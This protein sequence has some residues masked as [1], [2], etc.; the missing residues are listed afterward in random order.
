MFLRRCL[1]TGGIKPPE[2]AIHHSVSWQCR[3]IRLRRSPTAP[4]PQRRERPRRSARFETRYPLCYW[5]VLPPIKIS[6]GLAQEG[7]FRPTKT[8]Q[9]AKLPRDYQ[10]LNCVKFSRN[11]RVFSCN[12]SCV[13]SFKDNTFQPENTAVYAQHIWVSV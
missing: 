11:G 2:P 6:S 9:S 4:L 8:S 12:T 10:N 1:A 3:L 5:L 13:S 7:L